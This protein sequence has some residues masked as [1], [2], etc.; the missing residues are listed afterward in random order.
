MIA[1]QQNQGGGAAPVPAPAPAPTQGP[2]PAGA[3][4]PPIPKPQAL[5][6]GSFRDLQGNRLV[7]PA[8][9]IGGK[10][11]KLH[12]ALAK[13]M[14]GL[15]PEK[16]CMLAEVIPGLPAAKAG[17]ETHDIIVA[18]EGLPDAAEKTVRKHIRSLKPGDTM[19]VTYRR[20]DQTR[21]AVV[22]LEPWH[23]DHMIR[24]LRPEHFATPP[25]LETSVPASLA[26]VQALEQ[27]VAQLEKQVAELRKSAAAGH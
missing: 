17:L 8:A 23:P 7:P 24:P 18:V 15:D 3:T 1:A 10:L 21:T 12:G 5:Q 2:A 13:H 6:D 16:S 9:M 22:T 26:Q 20:G 11:E 27:R 25:V 14:A 19:K 4:A